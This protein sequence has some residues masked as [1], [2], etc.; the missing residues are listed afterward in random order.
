M[1][2]KEFKPMTKSIRLIAIHRSSVPF[3][4][5]VRSI[6]TKLGSLGYKIS[7]LDAHKAWK[8]YSDSK[9]K[10]AI[11]TDDGVEERWI[12]PPDKAHDIL[13]AIEP[14]VREL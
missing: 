9:I 12:V 7:N 13:A 14:F 10:V 1:N 6:V 2:P 11:I 4:D 5:D 3:E 8:D